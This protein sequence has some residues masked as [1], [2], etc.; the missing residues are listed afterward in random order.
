MCDVVVA[1][2]LKKML[3][4]PTYFKEFYDY[5]GKWIN[6]QMLILYGFVPAQWYTKFCD[7]APPKDRHIYYV[8]VRIPSLLEICVSYPNR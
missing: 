8:N 5:F 4:V 6:I 2:I 7:D 3:T 1:E